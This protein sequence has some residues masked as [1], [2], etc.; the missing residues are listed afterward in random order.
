MNEIVFPAGI[1]QTPFF[2]SKDPYYLNYGGIGAVV[3]HELTHAF[4]NNGRQYDSQGK[5]SNWVCIYIHYL[6]IYF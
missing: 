2:N 5:L 6:F 1:L 4:D 3:G